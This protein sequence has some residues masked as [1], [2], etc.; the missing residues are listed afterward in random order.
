[1]KTHRFG[2]V[3][4]IFSRS[5]RTKGGG[6]GKFAIKPFGNI[7]A[8]L[9]ETIDIGRTTSDDDGRAEFIESIKERYVTHGSI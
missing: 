1:M 3:R 6:D 5:R 4:N 9:P 2:D 8:E 7:M